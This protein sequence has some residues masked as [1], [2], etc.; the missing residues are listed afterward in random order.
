MAVAIPRSPG[1]RGGPQG[2]C[3]APLPLACLDAGGH[4]TCDFPAPGVHRRVTAA[5]L[6]RIIGNDCLEDGWMRR[7]KACYL[8]LFLLLGGCGDYFSNLRIRNRGSMPADDLVIRYGTGS[9][10]LGTVEPGGEVTFT[11]HIPGEGA[12][13]IHFVTGGQSRSFETCYYTGGFPPRGVI[14]IFDNRIERRC[15]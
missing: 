3:R 6:V 10:R 7:A 14:T 12:P 5:Y 4:R 13:T 1:E 2:P 9:D 8:G 15:A 11:R